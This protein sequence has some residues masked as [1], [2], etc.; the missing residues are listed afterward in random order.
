[1][2]CNGDSDI[3]PNLGETMSDIDISDIYKERRNIKRWFFLTAVVTVLM[4]TAATWKLMKP[5]MSTY[6]GT[7]LL[8]MFLIIGFWIVLS[9]LAFVL[10]KLK[11]IL[12]WMEDLQEAIEWLDQ[13]TAAARYDTPDDDIFSGD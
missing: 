5:D 11:H 4:L 8:I 10:L 13:K 12:M 9:M 1:M 2:K 3:N 7:A 6:D